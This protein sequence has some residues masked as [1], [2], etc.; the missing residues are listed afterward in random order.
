MARLRPVSWKWVIFGPVL[1]LLL[2]A[3][4]SCGEETV[5]EK[6]VTKEVPKEVIK[7]VEVTKEVVRTVEVPR[8]VVRTVVVPKEVVVTKEVVK[9]VP[10][11][12]IIER[13]VTPVAVARPVAEVPAYVAKGKYGGT[14]P[15][16]VPSDPGVLDLHAGASTNSSLVVS[17]PNWWSSTR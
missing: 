7:E 2:A 12:K 3:S 14:P 13:V 5:V 10:V 9:E 16:A 11:E 6:V 17:V 1:A 4:V 8:D 15:F